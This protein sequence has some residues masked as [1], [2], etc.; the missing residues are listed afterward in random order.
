M[1]YLGAKGAT[2]NRIA[3]FGELGGAGSV[4]DKTLMGNISGGSASPTALTIDQVN[5][6]LLENAFSSIY[7]RNMQNMLT[8]Y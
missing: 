3:T 7:Q 2:S 8:I 1:D 6:L 4:A 5:D